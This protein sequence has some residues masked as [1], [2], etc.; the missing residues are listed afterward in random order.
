MPA[1]RQISMTSA[2]GD[3]AEAII[4]ARGPHLA[5]ADDEEM[6]RVAGRDEAVRVEHQR[7]R[8]R[9]PAVA[10][11]QARMQ[12]SLECELSFWVLHRR[13]AAA[14][15]DGEQLEAALV[16][17]PSG[18]CLYSGTM[19]MVAPRD[20]DARVL[21]GRRAHAARDHQPD[22]DA[23]V[24]AVGVERVVEPLASAPRASARCPSRSPW[25]LRTG[26]R[27]GGRGRRSG[28]RG[29]AAPPTPRRRA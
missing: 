14:D 22:V 18:G 27:D 7:L 11:M 13:V 15:M 24:H 20:D 28:P 26:G 19:T 29:R 1:S 23:L 16:A 6:G 17:L 25:R 5:L 4:A 10:W 9:P 2:A 3:P 21:V 12:F 8:R